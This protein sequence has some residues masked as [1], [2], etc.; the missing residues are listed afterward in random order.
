MKNE[1]LIT[2]LIP[3][4]NSQD[5]LHKCVDSLL[6][7]ANY[8]S[9][10]III[11][12]D[13]STDKTGEIAEE[14]STRFPE[15]IKVIHQA[16]SGHGEGINQGIHH[17]SGSYFKVVD[18][19][20]WLDSTALKK[21]IK[22]LQNL[23]QHGGVDVIFS[24]YVY[25]QANGKSPVIMRYRN[26]MKPNHLLTW[27][28]LHSCILLQYFMMH[29]C[30]FNMDRVRES[31]V[32]LPKNLF[33]EDNI[34]TYCVLGVCRKLYY[35]DVNLYHYLIG[36][37]DQSV[38]EKI[39]VKRAHHQCRVAISVFKMYNLPE[40]KKKNPGL[41]RY[42]YHE[43]EYML[44]EAAIFMRLRRTDKSE[45]VIKKLW[46][47]IEMHDPVTARKL[48]YFSMATCTLIPGKLGREL[49]ILFYRISQKIVKF[50]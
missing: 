18:S 41:Y 40:I 20:D 22:R 24:N 8:A 17:A 3:C 26:V 33:Y 12:N 7:A 21:I 14:Y 25:E 45:A 37:E 5:Y 1:K 42:L 11:V 46:G 4:Y 6:Q 35:M 15:M 9:I 36:R 38:N 39:M 48:K 10:E 31:N 44:A 49:T 19:D 30:I 16:N 50:N 13:G 34:F 32:K 27:N 2:F 43:N 23:E 47:I 29:A 28:D